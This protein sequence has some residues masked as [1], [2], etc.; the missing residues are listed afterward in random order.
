MDCNDLF[1]F[2]DHSVSWIGWEPS[3]AE[4]LQQ[5]GACKLHLGDPTGALQDLNAAL[6]QG[7]DTV[8][9]RHYRAAANHSLGKTQAAAEDLAQESKLAS[10]PNVVVLAHRLQMNRE[11]RYTS[12][13]AGNCQPRLCFTGDMLVHTGH[14]MKIA[15]DNHT[16]AWCSMVTQLRCRIRLPAP[17]QQR[18]LLTLVNALQLDRRTLLF[19]QN[20][21]SLQR[22]IEMI[23]W[24]A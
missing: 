9:T 22:Q 15:E 3:P 12:T 20:T 16:S 19:C 4:L 23:D 17:F 8:V 5:L 14:C 21:Q 10:D 11:S 24:A 13:I 2:L 18:T 6:Q 1:C 7:L